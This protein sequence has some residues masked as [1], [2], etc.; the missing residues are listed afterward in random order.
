MIFSGTFGMAFPLLVGRAA[1]QYR[2][3]W[4]DKARRIGGSVIFLIINHPT[5]AFHSFLVQFSL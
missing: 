1:Q 4:Q 3:Q 5:T 2:A